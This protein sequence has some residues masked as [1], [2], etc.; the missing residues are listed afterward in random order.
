MAGNALRARARSRDVAF[1]VTGLALGFGVARGEAQ[2]RMILPDVGDLAPIGFVVAGD[3]FGSSKPLV[4]RIFV[5]GY[6][7]GLQPEIGSVAAAVL[8]IM[9]VLA[10]NRAV[11]PFERPTRLPMIEPFAPAARP[12][13]EPR[14]PSEVLDVTAAA[15][16]PAILAP[17]EAGLLPYLGTQILVAAEAGVGIEPLARRVA[18]TAIRIAVDVCMVAGELSGGQKLGARWARHQRA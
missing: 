13:N 8:A 15:V 14:L 16:L 5:A 17:V 10:S 6:A 11:S 9:T 2:T 12:S 7:V 1:V 3:A 18:L 4:V